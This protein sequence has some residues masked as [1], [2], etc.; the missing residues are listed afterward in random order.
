M[1]YGVLP[2]FFL[3]SPL[4]VAGCGGGVSART[5]R[6][7]IAEL[8]GSELVPADVD[9]ERIVTQTGNRMIA[10]A[11]I[12]MAFQFERGQNEEWQIV[13]VRL[14]DRQW[15]D[16]VTLL[17]ALESQRV[18]STE[19]AMQ[20]LLEGVDAFRLANSGALPEIGPNGNLS[21]VLHPL[22]MSEL[23][24]TDGW[25]GAIRYELEGGSYRLRAP[26]P[27]GEIGGL[28]DIVVRP[29]TD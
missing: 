26:G 29:G 16:V 5:A 15:L 27:D 6:S 28:D 13:A 9:V 10:E 3:I 2:V 25:G 20:Q 19:Q 18:D 24:R 23:I 17:E 11:T 4:V 7:Q 8:G 14:G 1:R 21:D 12:K 22:F